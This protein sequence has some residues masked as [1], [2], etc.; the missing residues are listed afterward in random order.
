MLSPGTTQKIVVHHTN[1]PN[2]TDYSRERA[3]ALAHEI[4]DQRLHG[5]PETGRVETVTW[6]AVVG[7]I[8]REE[9][10]ATG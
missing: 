9:F 1:F 3:I 10:A 6:C 2:T 8:V 4:Q 7:G 5:L